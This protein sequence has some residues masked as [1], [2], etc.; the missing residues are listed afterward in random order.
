MRLGGVG[1]SAIRMSCATKWGRT[2]W[3]ST[4]NG[5]APGV[6]ERFPEEIWLGLGSLHVVL[7]QLLG[8]QDDDSGT[9][10]FLGEDLLAYLVLALGAALFIGNVLAVVKPPDRANEGDLPRAPIARSVVMAVLGLL[11]AVWALASLVTN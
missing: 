10:V 1:T 2:S 3:S 4:D 8:Q 11:A 5:A 9:P 6:L 7:G